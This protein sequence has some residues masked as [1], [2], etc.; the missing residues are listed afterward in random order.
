MVSELAAFPAG[1]LRLIHNFSEE[2]PKITDEDPGVV[3]IDR[4]VAWIEAGKP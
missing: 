1:A 3:G 4:L 2:L